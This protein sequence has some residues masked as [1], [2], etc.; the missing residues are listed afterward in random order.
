VLYVLIAF[1]NIQ[2]DFRTLFV[3]LDFSFFHR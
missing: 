3:G 1:E 2:E